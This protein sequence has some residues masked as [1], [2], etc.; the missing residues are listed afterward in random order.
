MLVL[1]LNIYETSVLSILAHRT[2]PVWMRSGKRRTSFDHWFFI[3]S[4]D[5]NPFSVRSTWT[6]EANRHD[7]FGTCLRGSICLEKSSRMKTRVKFFGES[8]TFRFDQLS[9]EP[10]NIGPL[11]NTLHL[12]GSQYLLG[13]TLNWLW[14]TPREMSRKNLDSFANYGLTECPWSKHVIRLRSLASPWKRVA[15]LCSTEIWPVSNRIIN[16]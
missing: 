12:Y 9:Q 4:S 3:C 2:N 6:C 13:S 11:P 10:M 1:D 5:A 8:N 15:W 7:P 14:R 16:G